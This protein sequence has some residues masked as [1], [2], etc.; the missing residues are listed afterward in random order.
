[1]TGRVPKQAHSSFGS[2]VSSNLCRQSPM[3]P[4]EH[5]YQLSMLFW[6][7]LFRPD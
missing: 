1:M 6:Y 7:V 5:A 4:S 3:K 2:P